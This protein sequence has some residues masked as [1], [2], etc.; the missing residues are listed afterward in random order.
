MIQIALTADFSA[1]YRLQL[2]ARWVWDLRIASESL[3]LTGDRDYT[4][5][6]DTGVIYRIP[7]SRVPEGQ[8]VLAT[9]ETAAG[10]IRTDY[11]LVF[12]FTA[13]ILDP[14]IVSLTLKASEPLVYARDR[15]GVSGDYFADLGTGEIRWNP[16]GRIQEDEALAVSFSAFGRENPL[17]PN[18]PD[19]TGLYA[20]PAD[21]VRTYG[22]A[23]TIRLTQNG[24]GEGRDLK[25]EPDW[26]KLAA[27]LEHATAAID[28][29]A[30]PYLEWNTLNAT[31]YD[32]RQWI[33]LSFARY[34]LDPHQGEDVWKQ[35]DLALSRL[36]KDGK[37][38]GGL[39]PENGTGLDS[40]Y[41]SYGVA[42]QTFTQKRLSQW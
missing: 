14:P 30:G 37:S 32:S 12:G 2:P 33:A 10:V 15:A 19:L 40:R 23:E 41:L 24:N 4:V 36:R 5:D 29:A 3:D 26:G 28:S 13:E 35:A 11:P 42:P 25:T 17:T 1:S 16:E 27:H 8:I 31:E 21:F 6:L 18:Q 38:G 20:T 22:L 9:Y 34:H 7:S 39:P